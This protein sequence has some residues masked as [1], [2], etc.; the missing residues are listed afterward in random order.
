VS[1][2]GMP[3]FEQ[4]SMMLDKLFERLEGQ[5]AGKFNDWEADFIVRCHDRSSAGYGPSPSQSF[6][7]RKLYNREVG[8][9]PGFEHVVPKK[10]KKKKGRT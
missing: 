2:E 4:H 7:I 10:R 9:L 8:E 5:D 6:H 3:S 1:G